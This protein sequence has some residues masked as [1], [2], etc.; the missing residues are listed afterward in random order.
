MNGERM[1]TNHWLFGPCDIDPK[2]ENRP[3]KKV[4]EREGEGT[5]GANS[6]TTCSNAW[7][8][9]TVAGM[10]RNSYAVNDAS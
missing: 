2:H 6:K 4:G 7:A 5:V 10:E 3:K 9:F 8:T 1:Q